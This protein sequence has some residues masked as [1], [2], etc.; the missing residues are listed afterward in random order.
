MWTGTRTGI[1]L[2]LLFSLLGIALAALDLSIGFKVATTL[3]GGVWW[4]VLLDVIPLGL[5]ALA[6]GIARR[7]GNHPLIVGLWVGLVYGLV[8]GVASYVVALVIPGKATL[9]RVMWQTYEH[10]HGKASA[11]VSSHSQ[12]VAAVLHPAFANYVVND[13]LQMALFGC[14]FSLL[15]GMA[16]RRPRQP[17]SGSPNPGP[18]RQN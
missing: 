14:I 16:P 8:A 2:G 15:G 11:T 7:R 17:A 13:A 18:A 3:D 10:L 5:F 1:R 12:L 4:N 9:I 6:G